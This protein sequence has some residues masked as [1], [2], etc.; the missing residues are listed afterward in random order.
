LKHFSY[1]A[2]LALGLALTA[3]AV[4]AAQPFQ[5]SQMYTASAPVAQK[6]AH[7]RKK[8]LKEAL[9]KVLVRVT[10]QTDISRRS[11]AKKILSRAS[12]LVSQYGYESADTGMKLKASFSRQSVD[13]A[14]RRYNMPLWGS[15]RPTTLALIVVS[16]DN[17][18]QLLRQGSDDEAAEGLFKGARRRG[19]PVRLLGAGDSLSASA[20]TGDFR[21]RIEQ[22]ARSHD[23]Q[24]AVY[25]Q[26]SSTRNG[27]Q[28]SMTLLNGKGVQARW[29][30]S[31]DTSGKA[32]RELVNGLADH[33]AKRYAI[34]AN[35]GGTGKTLVAVSGIKS[36]AD[37][38]KASGYLRSLTA[39]DDARIKQIKGHT[40]LFQVSSGGG[41]HHLA[42]AISVNWRFQRTQPPRNTSRPGKSQGSGHESAAGGGGW[43]MTQPATGAGNS[44]DMGNN[45]AVGESV[46]GGDYASPVLYFRYKP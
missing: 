39:V 27:W 14:V 4:L 23:T 3:P 28:G 40:A 15:T 22:A 25:G 46:T 29:K 5:I 16:G 31:G 13:Q 1:I 6:N 34:A 12:A 36:L 21:D 35:Q 43:V 30:V 42:R 37:Y 32:L 2:A 18:R 41:R 38:A 24:H 17:G 44:S 26:L 19:L 8:A 11:G 10:G 9:A 7:Q 33:Y 20:I 45:G